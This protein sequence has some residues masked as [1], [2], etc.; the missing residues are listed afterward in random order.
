MGDAIAIRVARKNRTPVA[1]MLTLHHKTTVV[2]KYGCSDEKSHHLGGMPFL[3]WR[4]IEESKASGTDRIDFGRSDM[5]NEGLVLF[6]DRFGT[7]RRLL[8]YYR[9][10]NTTRAE[11]TFSYDAPPVRHFFSKLP[12]T[13]FSAAGRILYRHIG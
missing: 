9:Y 12:D 7:A 1:A 13:A 11:S 4:L 10:R 6:K 2:Y 3:F 8:T 5:N